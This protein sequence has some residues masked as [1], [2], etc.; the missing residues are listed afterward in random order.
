MMP[1]VDDEAAADLS[2]DRC[3]DEQM[4]EESDA[5]TN[6]EAEELHER[7]PKAKT[8]ARTPGCAVGGAAQRCQFFLCRR[9]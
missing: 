4:G 9:S 1:L 2:A 7:G 6:E 5:N 8:Q 3:A